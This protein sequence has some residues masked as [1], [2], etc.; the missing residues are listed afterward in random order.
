MV[1][2]LALGAALCNAVA[3]VLQRSAARSAPDEDAL[4]LRLVA[5]LLRRPIWLLG[6]LA[7]IASFSLQAA[8][9]SLG[10]LSTVQ[11]LLVSELLFVLAIIAFGLHVRIGRLE[12]A[13]ALATVIGLGGFLAVSTPSG[14]TATPS[15]LALGTAGLATVSVIAGAVVLSRRGPGAVRAALFGAAAG[16]TFALTAA[17]TKIFTD[18]IASGGLLPAFAGWTPYALVGTGIAA[19]FLAQ[20]AFQAGPLTASQPALTIVDPLVSV[21]LGVG[22]F[23]DHLRASGWA[24]VLESVS[25]AVMALGVVLLTRAPHFADNLRRAGAGGQSPSPQAPGARVPPDRSL[26]GSTSRRGVGPGTGQGPGSVAP[27]P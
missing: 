20:N 19:V 4:R 21:I 3:S 25:F 7:M 11:P 12:W 24:V 8:A 10:Q 13:G 14:G 15:A 6:I 23:G 27:A 16:T 2:V 18:A 26:S 5:H 17:M 22:M 1:I 9:L